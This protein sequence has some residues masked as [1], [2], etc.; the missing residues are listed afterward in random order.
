VNLAYSI[1][2]MAGLRV[3]EILALQWSTVDLD[4]RRIVVSEQVQ[5]GV[6]LRPKDLDARVVLIMDS[7]LPVLQ[8][9]TFTAA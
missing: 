4:R 8:A 5:D 2:A 7:L 1:G 6:V 9:A 3:G